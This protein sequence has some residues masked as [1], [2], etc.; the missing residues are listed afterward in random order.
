MSICRMPNEKLR[1]G[2]AFI[3][4]LIKQKHF[5]GC[6]SRYFSIWND[7]LICFNGDMK[8]FDK[9]DLYCKEKQS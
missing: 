3:Q 4:M 7:H 9:F 1:K 2:N 8:M 6:N 5:S